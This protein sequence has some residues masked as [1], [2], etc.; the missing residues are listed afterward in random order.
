MKTIKLNEEKGI[1]VNNVG[2]CTNFGG[3]AITG[4]Q[5]YTIKTKR[6][7]RI[8]VIS[9]YPDYQK[10]K[11]ESHKFKDQLLHGNDL[12]YY[13]GKLYVAP[14]GNF[15]GEIS[16]DTWEFRRIE[17]NFNVSAITHYKGNRFIILTNVGYGCFMLSMA[18]LSD[19]EMFETTNWV[20]ND[21]KMTNTEGYTISQSIAY[22]K[23]NDSVFVVFTKNDYQSNIVLRCGIFDRNPIICYQSKKATLGK[24]ELEGIDFDN[25]GRM[26]LGSNLPSGKDSIF[27]SDVTRFYGKKDLQKT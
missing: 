2:Q 24:Y 17:C 1:Q 15:V 12:T 13:N 5:M 25:E 16:T 4:K 9:Y 7:N 21:E 22:N 11:R 20:V 6:N 8:S 14:C 23:N 18:K 26:I 3:I 19:N 27:V 10:K